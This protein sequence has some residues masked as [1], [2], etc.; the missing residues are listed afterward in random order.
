MC[1]GGPYLLVGADGDWQC[2]YGYE[3]AHRYDDEGGSVGGL[4]VGNSGVGC[5]QGRGGH[6]G[7]GATLEAP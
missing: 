7:K 3:Y 6:G 1:C 4:T 5:I 2:G